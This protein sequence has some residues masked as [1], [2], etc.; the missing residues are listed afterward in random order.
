MVAMATNN[1][2]IMAK[3]VSIKSGSIWTYEYDMHLVLHGG[4]IIGI[5]DY[6]ACVISTQLQRC[7]AL[8]TRVGCLLPVF[9][10]GLITCSTGGLI[11]CSILVVHMR[12][13][14]SY[15]FLHTC[16]VAVCLWA[17]GR[18][19]FVWRCRPLCWVANVGAAY[20]YLEDAVISI[21]MDSWALWQVHKILRHILSHNPG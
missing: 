2:E 20:T 18:M 5:T 12:L 3:F 11:T 1:M 21:D 9:T 4:H 15:L 8:T 16:N 10:G 7:F 13:H 14:P 19:N 6:L 17:W